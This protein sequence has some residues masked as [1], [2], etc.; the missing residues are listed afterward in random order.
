[1][2][3][4]EIDELIKKGLQETER[5]S[6]NLAMEAKLRI[7]DTIEKP[8]K[9]SSWYLGFVM[10]MAAAVALFLVSTFLFFQLESKKEELLAEKVNTPSETRPNI[11]TRENFPQDEAIKSET[12]TL[13]INE[14]VP[15]MKKQKGVSQ[16]QSQKAVEVKEE[17][18]KQIPDIVLQDYPKA[19]L[20]VSDIE[21]PEIDIAELK[22]ELVSPEENKEIHQSDP[23]TRTPAKLRFRFGNSEPA[24][25]SNN[26]LALTI[27]L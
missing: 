3:F 16:S 26:S 14:P 13:V 1:M 10:A 6:E 17:V 15:E 18:G 7:W 11:K 9:K 25:N 27:K 21:I 19:E 2:H 5:K 20:K 12:Q 24:F 4:N 23:K 22:A 8:K